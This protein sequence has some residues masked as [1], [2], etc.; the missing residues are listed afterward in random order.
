[1]GRHLADRLAEPDRRPVHRHGARG[2]GHRAAAVHDRR[3]QP[4]HPPP[5][6]AGHRPSPP[7][8]R[9]RAAGPS[10]ASVGATPRCSTSAARPCRSPTSSRRIEELH[11]YLNGGTVD[12]HGRPSRLR[13]LDRAT[14]AAGAHRHRRVGAEGDRVR[15]PHRRADHLRR[16]RRSRADGLGPRPGPHGHGRGRPRPRRG[17]VRGLR[18]RRAAIPTGGRRRAHPGRPSPP[19]PTSRPCPARPAPVS[20][21]H[22]RETRGRG[23]SPLR[24]QPPPRPTPADHTQRARR[25]VRGALRRGRRSRS[26]RRLACGE[27]A[28]LGLD[29]FV[30]TGPTI[31]ADPVEARVASLLTRDELLPALRS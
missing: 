7:C 30:I 9:C 15:R 8:R 2:P 28:D 10:S 31:D 6:R 1:M 25:R 4:G 23:R 19:S 22:D 24:Q 18:E 27:L 20:T 5:R 26:L 13:W 29:R 21:P 16:R 11:T 3:D 17:V 12:Q 14:P